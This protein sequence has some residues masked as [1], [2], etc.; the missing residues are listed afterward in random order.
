MYRGKNI[1]LFVLAVVSLATAL[2]A[3]AATVCSGINLRKNINLPP[4]KI[5]SQKPVI[6]NSLCQSILSI[7]TPRGKRPVIFYSTKNFTL[8]GM[9]FHNGQNI[10]RNT[11]VKAGSLQFKSIWAKYKDK[12]P[13]V[14]AAVYT[15]KQARKGRIVYEIADPNCPFCKRMKIPTKKFA[16]KYGYIVKLIFFSFERPSSPKKTSNFICDHRTFTD[17]FTNDLGTKTCKKGDE[18][19]KK[20]NRMAQNLGVTGT[21]TYI[22]VKTGTKLVGANPTGLENLMKERK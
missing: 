16:D 8:V 12:L 20:A 21:P 18:Y 1:A 22:F 14:V 5:I 13:G 9:L 10:T 3:N 11:Q 4:Y 7:Q 15:P 6:N 19:V 17:Y 2:T